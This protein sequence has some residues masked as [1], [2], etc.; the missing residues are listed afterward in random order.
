LPAAI[1]IGGCGFCARRRLDDDVLEVPELPM[2]REAFLRGPGFEDQRE[3]FLEALFGLLDRDAEARELVVAIALADAELEPAVGHEVDGRRLLGEQHRIVPGQH[4]DGGAEPQRRR[5]RRHPGEQ[6]EAR[7]DL[8]E[9]GE[10]M[11]HHEGAVIPER[12]RLHIVLDEVLEPL[13]AVDI[14][15]AAFGLGAAE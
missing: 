5:P 4:H 2:M 15:P 13:G 1:Q 10:M 8:A 14:G 6:V 12:L 9:A 7:R 11:L 3:P